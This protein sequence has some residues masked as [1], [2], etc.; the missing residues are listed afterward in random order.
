MNKPIEIDFD[1]FKI[2]YSLV[3]NLIQ[4]DVIV[5]KRDKEIV[6]QLFDSLHSKIPQEYLEDANQLKLELP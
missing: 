3:F 6:E 4:N 1:D 5:D 2:I